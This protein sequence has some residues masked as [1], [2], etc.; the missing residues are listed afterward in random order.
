MTEFTI[1]SGFRIQG[2]SITKFKYVV[3]VKQKMINNSKTKG[4]KLL[5]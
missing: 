5:R 2:N 3:M 1:Y 4:E